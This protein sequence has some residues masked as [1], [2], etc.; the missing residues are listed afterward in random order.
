LAEEISSVRD[1]FQLFEDGLKTA[2]NGDGDQIEGLDQRD[3][4][5]FEYLKTLDNYKLAHPRGVYGLLFSGEQYSRDER[6][7]SNVV[8]MK[9]DLMIGIVSI[10]RYFDV[11]GAPLEDQPMMPVEYAELAVDTMAG[12]EIEN[13][14]P[15]Y[16]RKI[17]PL[18][19]ELVDETDGVWKY[20]TTFIVPRD[21]IKT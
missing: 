2:V 7:K 10:I 11:P 12:I 19:T 17:I 9:D 20:L 14:R 1:V 5:G 6:I 18:R 21:F 13:K 15:E 16:E 3:R 4:I 8:I